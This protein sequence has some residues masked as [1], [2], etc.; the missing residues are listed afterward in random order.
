MGCDC[1]PVTELWVANCGISWE[2]PFVFGTMLGL[3]IYVTAGMYWGM[4][5]GRMRRESVVNERFPG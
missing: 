4:R 1:V 2:L 3:L 5:G